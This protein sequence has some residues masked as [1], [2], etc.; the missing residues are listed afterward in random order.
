[1]R[2][3]QLP[4]NWV[5]KAYEVEKP[6]YPT[7]GH[8]DPKALKIVAQSLIDTNQM[9]PGTDVGRLITEQYLN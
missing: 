9:D 2:L 5:E 7:D 6:M 1:M 8:Y 4:Q 3:L